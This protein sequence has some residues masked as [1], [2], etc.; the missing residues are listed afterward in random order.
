MVL[1]MIYAGGTMNPKEIIQYSI[2]NLP[3]T[4]LVESWG[5]I[6]IFYNP[7]Q[8]LKRGIYVATIKQK[9]GDNDKASNLNREGVFRLNIGLS[10]KTFKELF[11]DIPKRPQAG[12]VVDMNFDFTVLDE[13]I[14]H[15]V[16]A[17]MGWVSVLNPSEET[18]KKCKPLVLEA[19]KLAHEKFKKKK[20]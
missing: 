2:T 3:D 10:K 17:W 9:D 8:K 1:K 7:Q 11:G 4:V 15:P 18:F 6:G 13:I 20:V 14:P 5:E 19:Y 16:Y 12:G